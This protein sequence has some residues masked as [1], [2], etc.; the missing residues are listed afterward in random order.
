METEIRAGGRGW[1]SAAAYAA[2][3]LVIFDV[4]GVLSDGGIYLDAHGAE[5]KRFDVR[6]GSGMAFLRHAGLEMAIV[7][8]RSSEATSRRAADLQIPPQRVWQGARHKGPI[9]DEVL[10]ACGVHREEVAFIGDDIVDLPI[11][12][13]AG[14]SACPGDARAEAMEASH[15]VCAAAGGHGAVRQFCEHLIKRRGMDVWEETIRKY[16]GRKG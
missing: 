13:Q 3:K 6:D 1:P 14:I 7:S 12:E 2:I 8:G 9:F 5:S 15:L 10:K 16:L 4:D 11:L